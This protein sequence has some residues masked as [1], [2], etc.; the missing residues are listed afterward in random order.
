MSF[1]KKLTKSPL[2]KKVLEE[3]KKPENKA[4]AKKAL[5]DLK[6]KNAKR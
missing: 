5:A 6:A 3:A 4:K 1:V 2:A